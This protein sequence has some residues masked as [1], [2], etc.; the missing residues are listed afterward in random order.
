MLY[1]ILQVILIQ[2]VFLL[3]Y[4]WFLQRE[5]FFQWNRFY[6]ILTGILSFVLPAVRLNWISHQ[7]QWHETLAPVI[8]G[9]HK[10][11]TGISTQIETG[12]QKELW[13]IYLAGL[14]VFLIIL[15]Y[16]L[17]NISRLISSNQII[18]KR[19]YKLVLLDSHKEAFT[20]LH[21]IFIHKDLYRQDD[22]SVLDHERVHIRQK[23][24]LDLLVFEVL[25]VI[26]WF[27][28]LLWSYQKRLR[29]VHEYIADRKI[30]KQR[31]IKAYFNQVLQETFQAR[32]ISFINQFY[33]PTL[34][35]KRIMM[36]NRKPSK[37]WTKIK[38]LGF[39]LILTGLMFVVDACKNEVIDENIVTIDEL[40]QIDS[41]DI[42]SVVVKRNPDKIT[43]ITQDG[44]EKVYYP[45]E[46]SDYSR[47]DKIINGDDDKDASATENVSFN[48]VVQPPVFP[49]CEE[50]T[51]EEAKKC[52]STKIE[53]FIQKNFRKDLADN[54]EISSGKVK[55]LT[56]FTIDKQ[57]KVMD[58]RVRSKY[59]KMEEEAKRVLSILP[60]MQAGQNK[61]EKV[62][63][64]YTLPIIF[65]VE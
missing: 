18:T 20:F 26:F 1:Y 35:K 54:L 50:L 9:S 46:P 52:F 59:K 21:Y 29:T 28:P 24:W 38:F 19:D 11:Q 17:F 6:L 3:F 27:N 30:L 60:Q 40:Q 36:Q 48:Q 37:H 25:K 45:K 31:N 63:V 32:N 10:L 55:I 39:V 53:E 61:G 12:Y 13:W 34:I 5:T 8:I 64:V 42:S 65:K 51:G 58:I 57:G 4:D 7:D 33:Q 14:S 22:W 2:L 56:M 15:F 62:S 16:K 47:I 44:S 49:G 43:I 41:K 23:H